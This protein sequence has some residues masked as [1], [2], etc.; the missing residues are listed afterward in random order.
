MPLP[1]PFVV[2]GSLAFAKVSSVMPSP[3]SAML[4]RT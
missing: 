4:M 1:T 2:K 3:V